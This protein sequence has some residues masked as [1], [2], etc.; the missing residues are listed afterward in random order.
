M[1]CL[2]KNESWHQTGILSAAESS[3]AKQRAGTGTAAAAAAAI[4]TTLGSLHCD[5]WQSERLSQSLNIA[6]N[7]LLLM[8]ADEYVA[9]DS[10]LQTCQCMADSDILAMAT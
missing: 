3:Q 4:R 7:C 6:L 10:Q 5:F 9:V 2:N 8:T 1:F